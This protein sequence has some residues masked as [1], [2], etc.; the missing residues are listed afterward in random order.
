MGSIKS[1]GSSSSEFP[2]VVG[3]PSLEAQPEVEEEAEREGERGA[4]LPDMSSASSIE[5]V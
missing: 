1:Y 4:S 2:G 3:T 5:K